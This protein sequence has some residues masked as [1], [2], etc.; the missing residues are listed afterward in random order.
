MKATA[1]VTLE[2]G[3][4]G[5]L[6]NVPG[7]TIATV[8]S[9][10]VPRVLLYRLGRPRVV[11]LPAAGDLVPCVGFSREPIVSWPRITVLACR[12]P[13]GEPAGAW[14]SSNGGASWRVIP[15]P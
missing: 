14:V 1:V 11:D 12:G 7:G 10:P 9:S 15:A 6:A 2:E 13:A 8:T 5:G 4:L 3:K